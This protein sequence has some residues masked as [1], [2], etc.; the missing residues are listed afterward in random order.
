MSDNQ[1]QPQE[2]PPRTT[3]G[4]VV[5]VLKLIL[6]KKRYW[7][8]PFWCVLLAIVLMLFLTGGGVLLPAIYMA[9]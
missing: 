3:I 2:S 4:F 7:L 6:S 5:W 1:L 8:L 9:F